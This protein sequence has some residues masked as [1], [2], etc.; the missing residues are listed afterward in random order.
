MSDSS[1]NPR[2]RIEGMWRREHEFFCYMRKIGVSLI[3]LRQGVSGKFKLR[4]GCYTPDFYD[5]T[6]RVYYEVAGSRQALQVGTPK[7][8]EMKIKYP[9][10]VL[11]IV[12]PDGTEIDISKERRKQ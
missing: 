8:R 1:N 2:E 11:K 12:R 6:H 9:H 4:R 7:Y 5:E 3:Y 10:I